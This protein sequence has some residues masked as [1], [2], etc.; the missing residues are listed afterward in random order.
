MIAGKTS[1]SRAVQLA[2][3]R[4]PSALHQCFCADTRL[5][6]L[7]FDGW[8]PEPSRAYARILTASRPRATP[9]FSR[10]RMCVEAPKLL[11]P[12]AIIASAGVGDPPAS[13]PGAVAYAEPRG[14]H[15][16]SEHDLHELFY[17]GA[18]GPRKPC[19]VASLRGAPP[20]PWRRSS[21]RYSP[22]SWHRISA[23]RDEAS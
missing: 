10:A 8:S 4:S 17:Y 23:G 22:F 2:K 15:A 12:D 7:G 13:S 21:L 6:P 5:F 9:I 3:A 11:T 19:V 14:S 18:S 20:S 16:Y 1:A